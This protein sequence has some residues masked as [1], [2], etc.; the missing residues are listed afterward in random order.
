MKADFDMCEAGTE[1]QSDYCV[2]GRCTSNE[3]EVTN[4]VSMNIMI[5]LVL[6]MVII[7]ATTCYYAKVKND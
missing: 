2:N 3:I 5:A 6:L 7:V 4:N 1:C